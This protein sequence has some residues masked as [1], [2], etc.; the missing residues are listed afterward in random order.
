MF[1]LKRLIDIIYPNR[2]YRN[3]IESY[4]G[5]YLEDKGYSKYYDSKSNKYIFE[6]QIRI[7]EIQN[8]IHPSDYG[9]SVFIF[10]KLKSNEYSILI[11]I[12][13]YLIYPDF[14]LIKDS[15]YALLANKNAT[16][17]IET[18]QWIP[19]LR[20]FWVNENSK[21]EKNRNSFLLK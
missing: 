14:I 6:N 17:S 10:N 3:C 9:F 16:D 13:N 4:F 11:N 15:F 7:V 19:K 21:T 1:L 2:K 20:V 8:K 12:P 18:N 5:R